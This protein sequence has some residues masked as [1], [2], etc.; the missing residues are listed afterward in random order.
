LQPTSA[1]S[2]RFGFELVHD[3]GAS[4]TYRVKIE[5]AGA[6]YEGTAALADD[7]SADVALGGADAALVAK[8]H[9]FGKLIARGVAKRREDGLVPWPRHILRWRPT[10]EGA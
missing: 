5:T 3:G 9:M 2:A 4:A 10:G 6:T 8:L 7:G 1:N